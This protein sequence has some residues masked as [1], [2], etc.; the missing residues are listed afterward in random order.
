MLGL[1]LSEKMFIKNIFELQIG[2]KY[3]VLPLKLNIGILGF[4]LYPIS[5][6]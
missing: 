3:V 6:F 5:A 4:F 2:L 1:I